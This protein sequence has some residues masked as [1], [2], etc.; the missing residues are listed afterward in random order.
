VIGTHLLPKVA[1]RHRLGHVFRPRLIAV[2]PSGGARPLDVNPWG[3]AGPALFTLT[4]PRRAPTVEAYALRDPRRRL[5]SA[6]VPLGPQKTDRRHFFIA[7]WSGPLPD[8]YVVDRNRK[9]RRPKLEPSLMPWHVRIYSGES[10]FTE[11]I[12]H[13]RIRRKLSRLISKYDY[14]LDLAPRHNRKPDLV[15]VTRERRTGSDRTEV[16]IISGRSRY[17]RFITHAASELPQRSGH[18]WPFVMQPR[19]GKGGSVLLV[20]TEDATLIL[21]P[22]VLP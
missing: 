4:S 17:R 8:L 1:E 18:M 16:H 19:P 20:R 15:L 11:L 12:Q 21:K 22:V 9:R 5:L 6:R 7:T 10:G 2:V 3:R 14:W 13:T